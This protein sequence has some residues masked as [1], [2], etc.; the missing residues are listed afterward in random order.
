MVMLRL[1]LL[2]EYDNKIIYEYYPE[3]SNISGRISIDKKTGEIELIRQ[4]END[5]FGRYKVH[6]VS[7]IMNY[8]KSKNYKMNE[9][10]AWC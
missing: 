10:I 5:K 7:A 3:D 4:A 9:T 6:A 2:N 1:K 8:F